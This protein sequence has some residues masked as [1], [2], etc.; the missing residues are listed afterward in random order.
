MEIKSIQGMAGY[1]A[2]APFH[3]TFKKRSSTDMIVIHC[4]ATQ[5]KDNIDWK[6]IDQMHR[7]R[8]FLA[9]GYHFVIKTDG[10]IQEGRPLDSIGAHAQGYNDRS[11][12]I[13]LIGG[14]N[15]NGQSVNN[16][17]KAQFHSLDTLVKALVKE[18]PT[19][20][21]IVGHRDLPGVHKDCPCF[22]AVARYHS[23]L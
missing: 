19:I 1:E 10:T 16:F 5:P 14:I 11:I 7:Q 6:T 3:L 9:I 2:H 8:G 18:Y 15:K 13:C 12:G 4:A 20:D 22:D 17:T 21:Q 23:F